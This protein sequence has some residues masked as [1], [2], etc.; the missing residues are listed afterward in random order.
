M[1]RGITDISN[2]VFCMA[3]AVDGIRE[4]KVP[5]GK[6]LE[7]LQKNIEEKEGRIESQERR[8][9]RL[10]DHAK[11]IVIWLDRN[12]LCEYANREVQKLLGHTPEELME[13]GSLE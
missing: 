8:F 6:A 10:S 7:A 9:Q 12:F 2:A 3:K 13:E 4:E 1:V 11:D 5:E